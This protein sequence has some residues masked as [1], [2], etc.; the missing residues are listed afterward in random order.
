MAILPSKGLLEGS[1]DPDTTS[2]E[3]RVAMNNFREY[4]AD[5]LGHDSSD[6]AKARETLGVMENLS[7]KASGSSDVLE[8]EFNVPIS[9]LSDGMTVSV[10]AETANLTATP[11]FQAG[12]TD[13]LPIVK[14]NN[15]QLVAGDIAGEGHW[16]QLKYDRKLNKWLLQNPATGI[17]F[18]AADK[19]DVTFIRNGQSLACIATGTGNDMTGEFSPPVRSLQNGQTF[20]VRAC[21][22][23]TSA[24]PTFK[25]GQTNTLT[26]VKGA[27][28]PLE[29]GDIGGDGHWMRLL[30]DSSL[31]KWILQNPAKGLA[32]ETV[33]AG[34]VHFFGAQ[35]VPDGYLAANGEAVSRVTYARLF[36]VIGTVFGEGDGQTS[37]NLPD[38]R[39]E[40]IRGWDAGRNLDPNRQ[41]ASVQEDAIRNITGQ[42][43]GGI[44]RMSGGAF[45]N[46]PNGS[47]GNAVAGNNAFHALRLFDASRVVPV[48]SDNHP[49][50]VAFLAC[51]KY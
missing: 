33:P 49:H 14:G 22:G 3:F 26:I 50:N 17:G 19:A 40:F 15:R 10:R 18:N 8:A 43:D 11:T 44:G 29:E 39:G 48:G 27:N 42:F 30:Y 36:S 51:I 2:G 46:G 4:L 35:A 5:L 38:L 12:A 20:H 34:S 13:A 9:Q 31:N 41:F 21:G 6:K 16:L 23:N 32:I 37:F 7:G 28:L 47:T 25:A 24:Q 45:T 1:K